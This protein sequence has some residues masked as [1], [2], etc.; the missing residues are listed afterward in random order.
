VKIS[1]VVPAFNEEKLIVATL[2]AIRDAQTAFHRLGWASEVIVCD[3]HSTDRTAELAHAEGAA[4]VSEPIRQISRARN[5]GASAATGDWLVFVDAD[6]QPSQSLFADVAVCIQDGRCVAGGAVVQLEPTEPW[7]VRWSHA[8]N[9]L[10]HSLKWMAGSF[11]FCDA[12]V[13]R[14]LGGFSEE[15]FVSEEIEFSRRVKRWA[16]LRGRQI[17]ILRQ[18]PLRTSAR[19]V[20]LY[21]PEELRRFLWRAVLTLGRI[22]RD[23]SACALWYDG[24]R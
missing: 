18:H 7:A 2:R 13:F 17:V 16:R 8:W 14:E 21:R 19:K 11:V 22:K 3:N 5:R 9:W 23:R 20:H 15:L 1:V 12:A 4:V 24:R 10:S 6:S